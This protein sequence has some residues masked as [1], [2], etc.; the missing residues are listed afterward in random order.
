MKI[1]FHGGVRTVTGSKHL[2]E[3][4]GRKILLECGLFQGKREEARKRN[5]EFPFDAASIDAV[6]LSHAHIDHSGA[7]PAL[8]RAG[9]DGPVFCTEATADLLSV[10]LRD[11]AQIAE[12]DVYYLN[13]RLPEG[14]PPIEPF[15]TRKDVENT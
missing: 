7:L 15:Y 10:L 9:F 13:K 1:E 3:V 11:S 8:V 6:I 12:R 14:A 5:S 4:N 2:L